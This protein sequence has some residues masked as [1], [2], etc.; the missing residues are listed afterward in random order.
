MATGSCS[1]LLDD[2][3]SR[4]TTHLKHSFVLDAALQ[5]KVAYVIGCQSNRAGARFLM[6]CA[7]AKLDAPKLDIRKPFTEAYAGTVKKDAFSGRRYDE[8]FLKLVLSEPESGV[9]QAL[10]EAFLALRRAAEAVE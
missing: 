10:K 6:A 7:L 9:N 1:K 3:F 4:A 2:S 5:E 8:R